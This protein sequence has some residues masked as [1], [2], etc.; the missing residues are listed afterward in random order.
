MNEAAGVPPLLHPIT[1][2]TRSIVLI[3]EESTTRGAPL[4]MG[5]KARTAAVRGAGILIVVNLAVVRRKGVRG[6]P[7]DT[8]GVQNGCGS[9][10]IY[11]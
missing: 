6:S 8:V 7:G 2:M 5:A 3:L 10:I 4:W 9:K 11:V 1:L